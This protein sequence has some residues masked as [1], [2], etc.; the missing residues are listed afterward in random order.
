MSFRD[1]QWMPLFIEDFRIDTLD[2]ETD[3]IGTYITMIWLAWARGDGSVSGDM[4]EL[5]KTLQRCLYKFHGLTFNRIVPKLLA[6][7]F[8]KRADGR[9]YQKRVEKELRI[10]REI[11]ENASRNANKR[12][13]DYRHFKSLGNAKAMPTQHIRKKEEV[14]DDKLGITTGITSSLAEIIKAKGWA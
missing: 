12:W 14:V 2:L 6:R 7:Y 5:K 10:A 4:R 3:E 8:E 13:S 9:Y 11:S 1:R